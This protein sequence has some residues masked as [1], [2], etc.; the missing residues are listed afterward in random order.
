MSTDE[1]PA[2]LLVEAIG[3]FRLEL[4]QWIDFQLSLL[5][6]REA[7]PG[8]AGVAAGVDGSSTHRH[9]AQAIPMAEADVPFAP[10]SPAPHEVSEAAT[11]VDPRLR[12][13]ALARRLGERIRHSEETRKGP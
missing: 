9:E 2:D 1:R 4:M 3:E 10:A 13:D 11:Q 5:S 8:D 7:R 6:Q 12:L